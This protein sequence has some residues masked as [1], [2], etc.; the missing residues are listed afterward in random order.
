MFDPRVIQFRKEQEEEK[1]RKRDERKAA[2]LAR[3][4]EAEREMREEQEA[5]EAALRAEEEARENAKKDAA[6]QNKLLRKKRPL[7][8]KACR[9]AH[10][11]HVEDKAKN[12]FYPK[13]EHVEALCKSLDLPQMNKLLRA[14]KEGNGAHEFRD[15]LVLLKLIDADD[16]YFSAPIE[17]VAVVAK[18]PAPKP[19]PVV[20][21]EKEQE[22]DKEEPAQESASKAWTPEEITALTKALT[23]FPVGTRDRYEKVAT[24][25]GT[26]SV[27]EVIAQTNLA[28]SETAKEQVITKQDAF[29]RFKQTKK[30]PKMQNTSEPSPSVIETP[31]PVQEEPKPSSAAPEDWSPE[32]Q[33][34]LEA[35]MKKYNAKE[36]DRW[37]KI[38]S[39]VP[40]R[41]KTDCVKRYKYLVEFFKSQQKK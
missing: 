36:T 10:D 17:R 1:Q 9:V 6:A 37:N 18:K 11:A 38:A 28:K 13:D 15:L 4:A 26:R 22:P 41:S 29:T 40:S 19:Q 27:K 16:V 12:P 7:L 2:K 8:R 32:E 20:E 24:L 14:F 34:L 35:A 30:E 31:T 33:K 39:E 3:K 21:K 23:K 25:V 5:K